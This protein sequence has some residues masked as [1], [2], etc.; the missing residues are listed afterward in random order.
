MK[1]EHE[2]IE[3][4]FEADWKLPARRRLS[5]LR[6]NF[7]AEQKAINRGADAVRSFWNNK[8]LRKRGLLNK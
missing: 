2:L 7:D 1:Q 3:L 8:N 6:S 4:P 5:F